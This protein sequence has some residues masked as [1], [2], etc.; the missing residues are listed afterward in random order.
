MILKINKTLHVIII[1][2]IIKIILKY[3]WARS[4][5]LWAGSKLSAD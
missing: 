3:Q 4:E 1:I 5:R 2:I